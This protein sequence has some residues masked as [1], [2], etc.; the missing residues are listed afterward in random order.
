M[1]ITNNPLLQKCIQFS[2]SV[3]KYTEHLEHQQKF[4]IAKQLLRCATSI[5]AN[6]MKAQSA[7]SKADFIHKLK[8]ADKEAYEALYWLLLCNESETYPHHT[9][10]IPALEEIMKLL[11]SII[12]TSKN[13]YSPR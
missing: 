10:L 6:A 2:L 12:K 3:I 9:K 7:E 13:N 5:G 8:I 4:V 1:D 11:N